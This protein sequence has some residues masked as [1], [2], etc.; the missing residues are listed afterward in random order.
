[1]GFPLLPS[2]LQF[3]LRNAELDGVLH[4]VNVDHVSILDK[5]DRPTD[6]GLRRD[7]TDAEPVR[8]MNAY[9]TPQKNRGDLG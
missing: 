4:C 8:P 7:V 1:M 9:V 3:I 2:L 6:L 5:G